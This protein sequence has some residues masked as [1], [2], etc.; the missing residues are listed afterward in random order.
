MREI[1]TYIEESKTC[2]IFYLALHILCVT[3]PFC[4]F[5]DLLLNI[6]PYYHY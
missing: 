1:Q 4:L 3:S 2:F 5:P 6:F